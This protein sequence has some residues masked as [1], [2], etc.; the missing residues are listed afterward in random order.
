M[1][2]CDLKT[3]MVV[4]LRDNGYY[5]VLR[6]CFA[7]PDNSKDVLWR[8]GGFW[9][10][11]DTYTEDMKC[12]PSRGIFDDDDA[13]VTENDIKIARKFDI[14]AVIAAESPA[15]IAHKEWFGNRI[16]WTEEDG[17]MNESF[18]WYR[19]TKEIRKAGGIK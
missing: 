15:L 10:P 6:D 13:P 19:I 12:I 1:K 7:I 9:M 18:S 8:Q 4:K 17:D 16:L 2:P 14:V 11:L 5:M 3:G